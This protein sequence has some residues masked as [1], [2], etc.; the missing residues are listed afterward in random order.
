MSNIE[1]FDLSVLDPLNSKSAV[2]YVQNVMTPASVNK[3]TTTEINPCVSDNNT[4]KS[5]RN[6]RHLSNDVR[7]NETVK[8]LRP[9]NQDMIDLLSSQIQSGENLTQLK[10]SGNTQSDISELKLMMQ[11]LSSTM[12]DFCVMM[13]SRMDS[14]ESDIVNKIGLMVDSKLS[15]AVKKVKDQFQ[16]ELK[17]VTDKVECI[18]KSYAEA[19]KLNVKTTEDED[20]GRIIVR[21]MPESVNENIVNKVNGLIRDGLHLKDVKVET[22]DRKKSFKAGK[23]GV[24]VVALASVSDKR[25]VLENKRELKNSHNY[26]DIFIENSIPKSQRVMNSNLRN[27]IKVI[28]DDKLEL[29][30]TRVQVK[31]PKQFNNTSN[32]EPSQGPSSTNTDQNDNFNRDPTRGRSN[33]NG[34]RGNRGGQ[35]R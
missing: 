13:T 10:A 7:T 21:N 33:D 4:D 29:R 14:F 26:K 15:T 24:I 23:A 8:K 16:A 30:G 35:A 34:R 9:D 18:E 32:P 3:I 20:K 6:K 22:A 25:K 11:G 5:T 31:G 17:T 2:N 27:I 1:D 28:G 12:N 19:V